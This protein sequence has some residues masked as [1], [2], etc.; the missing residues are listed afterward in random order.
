MYFVQYITSHKENMSSKPK[1]KES[2]FLE[3]HYHLIRA[4]IIESITF[5]FIKFNNEFNYKELIFFIPFSFLFEIIFDFFHYTTHRLL[6]ENK[7]LYRLHKF[8]HKY[9]HPQIINTFSHSPLDLIITN[10][11]PS[12][13]TFAIIPKVS[14]STLH[15]LLVY[16]T[17]TE[18]NGHTGKH[19]NN[20]GSF[21]QFIWLPKFL[22]IQLY[23]EN[24]ELHHSKGNCNY[25]KRFSFWDKLFGTYQN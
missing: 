7:K 15:L 12:L 9:A 24:H 22:K 17:C 19:S 10:S 2:F 1:I 14:A 16:K 23:T 20:T 5:K 18:L 25:S 11:I 13:L 4:T 21:P 6:H 3:Y 8:H